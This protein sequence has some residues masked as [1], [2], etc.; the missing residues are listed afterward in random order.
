MRSKLESIRPQVRA[1]STASR[2]PYCQPNI[3]PHLAAAIGT[4]AAAIAP[5]KEIRGRPGPRAP[6]TTNAIRKKRNAS[7]A[8]A[9]TAPRGKCYRPPR[10]IHSTG[11]LAA[12][13]QREAFLLPLEP[14]DHCAS[15]RACGVPKCVIRSGAPTQTQRQRHVGGGVGLEHARD[16]HD[17][18]VLKAGQRAR[19]L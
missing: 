19:L 6:V 13:N 3:A 18:R 2:G 8:R 15:P 5:L 11:A 17:A 7:A 9:S 12:L 1:F 16:A 14:F 4:I 10:V